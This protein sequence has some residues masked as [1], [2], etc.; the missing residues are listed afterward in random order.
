MVW[1]R[2]RLMIYDYVFEPVKQI[3]F[4]FAGRRPDFFY[5]KVQELLRVIFNVPEGYIQEKEYKWE[6]EKDV[7]RFEVGWE[8][9]KIFDIYSYLGLEIDMK[10]FVSAEGEGKVSV[11]IKPRLITEY[12]QDT[13]WQQSIFYEMLRRFWHRLY[14]H[15]KRMNY[16]YWS[17]EATL[18]F[19][20][21]LK[22]FAEE[23]RTA[24]K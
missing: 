2:T 17:K 21:K 23:L 6:K 15:R 13:I 19:E 12:P 8:V 1:A 4:E 10:G 9:T 20:R 18:D 14:Y 11:V 3:R 7:E 16:L 24:P 5:K 22:D